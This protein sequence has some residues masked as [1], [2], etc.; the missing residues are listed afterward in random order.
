MT[1]R[2]KKIFCIVF[3]AFYIVYMESEISGQTMSVNTVQTAFVFLYKGGSY[4]QQTLEF[5]LTKY[6]IKD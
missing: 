6:N 3:D 4:S 1:F 5:F 2:Q